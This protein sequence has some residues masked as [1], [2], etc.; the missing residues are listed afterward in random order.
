MLLKTEQKRS[1]L[2]KKKAFLELQT[3]SVEGNCT[4]LKDFFRHH[5]CVPDTDQSAVALLVFGLVLWC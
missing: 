1:I 5:V 2:I 4:F 3:M